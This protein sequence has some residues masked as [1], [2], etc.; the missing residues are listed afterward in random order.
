MGAT[1]DSLRQTIESLTE[2]Q[3][4]Q[5]L[6]FVRSLQNDKD[7]ARLRRLLGGNPAFK[8]PPRDHQFR[9]VKP[10]EVPGT[11]ASKLLIADRR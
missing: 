10:V 3:A 5:T 8:L 6:D 4:R 2:E 1:K 9:D 11:P 7:Y